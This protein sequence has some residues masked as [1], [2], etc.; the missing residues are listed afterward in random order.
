V[1]R[2]AL[3]RVDEH[4]GDRVAGIP[5][6]ERAILTLGR[7]GVERVVADGELPA[8]IRLGG[9]AVERGDRIDGP[10][11]VVTTSEV[12]DPGFA[13][14]AL[15]AGTTEVP[16]DGVFY[17]RLGDRRSVERALLGS[18]RKREDGTISRLMNR[19]MSLA[20]T[21]V[22]MRAR[23]TPN[24]MTIVTTI[25]GLAGVAL[26][27]ARHIIAGAIVVNV[28]SILDGC[29]GEIARL[30]LQAS[31][32]G[33]W[34]D[35]VLDDLVNAGYGLA[36]GFAVGW[37]IVGIAA[38][39]AI[40]AYDL[41]VYWQLARRHGGTGN[42]AAFRWW[43]Q[44]ADTDAHAHVHASGGVMPAVHA[45]ARRDFYL[46]A[47]MLLAIAR[48]PKIAVIWYAAMAGGY[49]ILTLVHLG[50]GGHRRA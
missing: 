4:A 21:S 29:D 9:V 35:N 25:V 45:V 39:A 20:L 13:R 43:F 36:L 19:R 22:L 1:L 32:T 48:V 33:E 15:A 27:F 17:R 11:L 5:M 46:F 23:I 3:L 34:L 44:A 18:L 24:Q 28:S 50:A 31:R 16:T 40:Y 37:P 47:W 41:L 14:R 38:T 10:H 30:K 8:G 2:Q 12:F 7:A 6:A 49:L 42:P 26:V